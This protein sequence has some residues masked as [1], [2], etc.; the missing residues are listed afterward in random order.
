MNKFTEISA[1]VTHPEHTG[2]GYAKQLIACASRKI[3]SLGN[4]PYLHVA[5]TNIGAIRLYEKLGFVTMR[6]ISLWNF[7]KND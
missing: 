6:K 1:V 7:L 4:I 3:F 5:D 2:K